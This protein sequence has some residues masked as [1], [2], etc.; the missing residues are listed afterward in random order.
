M[1]VNENPAFTADKLAPDREKGY[2]AASFVIRELA[3]VVVGLNI[4][5]A[6][7]K[8][9]LSEE[10]KLPNGSLRGG[11]LGLLKADHPSR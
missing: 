9:I 1:P 2:N 6:G 3:P 10:A 4:I 7:D 5:G 11:P 8:H